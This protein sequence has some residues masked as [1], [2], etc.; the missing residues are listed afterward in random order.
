MLNSVNVYKVAELSCGP[1]PYIFDIYISWLEDP[2][3][4]KLA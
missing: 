1:L 2:S 4:K 3:L